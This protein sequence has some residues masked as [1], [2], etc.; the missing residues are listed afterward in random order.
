MNYIKQ[1]PPYISHDNVWKTIQLLACEIFKAQLPQA[2]V[3][4]SSVIEEDRK[5]VAVLVQ[6]GSTNYP[7]VF[8]RQVIKLVQRHQHIARHFS[9]RL[10]TEL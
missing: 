5:G 7:Q 10:Q 8:Q 1:F 3:S 4:I 9:D 6:L 2:E